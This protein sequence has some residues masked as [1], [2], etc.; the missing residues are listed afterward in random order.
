M[1]IGVANERPFSELTSTA[2]QPPLSV[3]GGALAVRLPRVRPPPRRSFGLAAAAA[4]CSG[5]AYVLRETTLVGRSAVE[6]LG[7]DDV[8]LHRSLF[9][10]RSSPRAVSRCIAQGAASLTVRL[11]G[12]TARGWLLSMRPGDSTVGHPECD[13]VTR[14]AIPT[15]YRMRTGSESRPMPMI[16]RLGRNT[17]PHM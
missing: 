17:S 5:P 11:V 14:P 9:L 4:I 13:T 15:A 1:R 10:V 7:P 16:L 3:R 2:H 12:A 8:L 6:L